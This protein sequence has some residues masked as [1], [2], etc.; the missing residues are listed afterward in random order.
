ML[1][2]YRLCGDC[3]AKHNDNN[4]V[5]DSLDSLEDIFMKVT[6]GQVN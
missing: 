6:K 2:L 4:V 1:I 3:V 5:H